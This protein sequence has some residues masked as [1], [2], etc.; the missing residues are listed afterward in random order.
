MPELC[1]SQVEMVIEQTTDM[2]AKQKHELAFEYVPLSSIKPA[3]RNPKKHALA[4]IRE[5][6]N[7]FG[8]VAPLIMNRRTGRLVGGHGR[9][10]ALGDLKLAGQAPP[11]NVKVTNA[12]WLVPVIYTWFE[13]AREAEAYLLTDN[14][15]T[16]VGGWDAAELQEILKDFT[17][18]EL[19]L[20]AFEDLFD[21][22][23]C[24]DQNNLGARL[25]DHAA[26]LQRK[27]ETN[28]GQLWE[29][30]R[31]RILCGDSTC[32]ADVAR[33]MNSKRACLFVTDPPYLVDYDGTNHP[34]KWKASEEIK[35]RKNKDWSDKYSDVDDPD[36]GR[37]LYES[38]VSVAVE[39]AIT[40]EAAWYCWHASRNQS[41][42]EAVWAKH[43]AFVHQQIIWAKDRPILT[44]S[45]YMWQ[46]EPC[47]FGWVKGSK[48][49]RVSK[50]FP[51]TVWS[52]PTI[53]PGATTD[54]PT[55]KPVE[56]FAIPM[57]QHTRKG[58]ICYEPFAGSGT[59]LVAAERLGRTCYAMELSPPFVAVA[60]E[61]LACM[62]LRPKLI[63]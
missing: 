38:F 61:R 44:R 25:V 55:Q 48:P 62:G 19:L 4:V 59:Q 40:P 27:W 13:N 5:S 10:H 7:R 43:G 21:D 26:E 28:S 45:W 30:G 60:L 20:E 16:I 9:L 2:A 54:H 51:G 47:F 36:L 42:L 46:H 23:P 11:R 56:L 8:Y 49:K 6:I 12:D 41:L 53:K 14:Q 32:Q 31:H 29:I 3:T 63:N 1:H 15:T 18:D 24:D 22:E 57:K 39:C 33:L 34:H 35:R 17:T 58:D 50:D 52:F 37:A